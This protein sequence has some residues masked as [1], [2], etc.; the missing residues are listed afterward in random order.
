LWHFLDHGGPNT[1]NS[2]AA[3]L[4]QT[5]AMDVDGA[6]A[7]DPNESDNYQLFEGHGKILKTISLSPARQIACSMTHF[8]F[9]LFD[10]VG[11]AC[12]YAL[13]IGL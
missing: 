11:L 6:Y 4:S 1:P 10:C 13:L 12:V 8:I 3:D 2:V 5:A 9:Y 7:E